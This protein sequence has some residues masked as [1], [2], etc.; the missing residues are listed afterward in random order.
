MTVWLC[1]HSLSEPPRRRRRRQC[2]PPTDSVKLP[3]T[4]QFP[5]DNFHRLTLTVHRSRRQYTA[6]TDSNHSSHRQYTHSTSP[7]QQ[8]PQL[9]STVST[10]HSSYVLPTVSTAPTDNIHIS[11]RQYPIAPTDSAPTDSIHNSRRKYPQLS[12]SDLQPVRT[13][14]ACSVSPVTVSALCH[15]PRRLHPIARCLDGGRGRDSWP[16]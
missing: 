4:V 9:P 14:V 5:I 1:C 6:H 12:H 15:S 11:H 7:D 13:A 10:L 2:E 3:P 16:V 8:Y